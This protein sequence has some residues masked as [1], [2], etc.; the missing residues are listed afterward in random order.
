LKLNLSYFLKTFSIIKYLMTLFFGNA[1]TISKA[2]NKSIEFYYWI[3]CLV[4]GDELL[5][6]FE[7]CF[8]FTFN[9]LLLKDSIPLV[10][11]FSLRD[12]YFSANNS[13]QEYLH[14]FRE[15]IWR[16]TASLTIESFSIYSQRYLT[17]KVFTNLALSRRTHFQK[18][19]QTLSPTPHTVFILRNLF[20]VKTF[21][22]QL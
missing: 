6:S 22:M 5:P 7:F 18:I 16:K 21:S 3:S 10:L 1:N 11:A 12:F 13:I 14:F 9:T 17:A 2:I 8:T 19:S 20:S 15:K 4:S